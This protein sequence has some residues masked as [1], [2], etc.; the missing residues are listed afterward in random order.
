MNDPQAGYVY[1]LR[2]SK[3]DRFYVG[4]TMRIDARLHEHNSG[5]V[6]ATRNRGPWAVA[7]L[8]G[9]I[10]IE[11]A[12]SAEFRIKKLKSRRVLEEIVAGEFQS[13]SY[14][15]FLGYFSPEDVS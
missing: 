13:D 12:R 9:F 5:Q 3:S 7:A 4:S 6:T 2:S 11:D 1:I 14:P 10:T 8:L 15:G